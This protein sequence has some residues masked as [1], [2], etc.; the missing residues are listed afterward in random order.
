MDFKAFGWQGIELK[1][2]QDWELS[3]ETGSYK[4]GFIRFDDTADPRLRIS[5]RVLDKYK[6][7]DPAHEA[8]E[9][10]KKEIEKKDKGVRF[11]RETKLKISDHPSRY[12]HWRGSGERSLV[13]GCGLFWHCPETKRGFASVFAFRTDEYWN[14][15]LAIQ[16]VVRTISC[17]SNGPRLWTAFGLNMNIPQDFHLLERQYDLKCLH[18]LFSS[19]YGYF[20][21]D[22]YNFGRSLKKEDR[23]LTDWFERN[24]KKKIERL[25]KCS[26]WGKIKKAHFND[27]EGFL[28]QAFSK[29][30]VLQRTKSMSESRV[31]HCE[32]KDKIYV[33]TTVRELEGHSETEDNLD[34]ILRSVVCH[35]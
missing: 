4:Q 23:D 5:W 8:L 15:R 27:H 11:I 31:W 16:R 19:A 9:R 33:V 10:T 3:E 12:V 1:I 30:T 34:A 28:I 13:E 35:E 14:L 22:R 7:K 24:C 32:D 17:H 29:R 20:M 26:Q 18:L 2:P 21:I 25:F 6:G